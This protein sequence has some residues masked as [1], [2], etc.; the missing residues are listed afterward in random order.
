MHP[1]VWLPD[2]KCLLTGKLF[3]LLCFLLGF[4]AKF[5]VAKDNFLTHQYFV[6]FSGIQFA[7]AVIGPQGCR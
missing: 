2:A 7:F 4:A 5:V 1:A 6:I 3:E